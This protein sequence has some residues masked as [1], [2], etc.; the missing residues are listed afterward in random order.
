[1]RMRIKNI[2]NISLS[3]NT[4]V[5]GVL[6]IF[7]YTGRTAYSNPT[8]TALSNDLEVIYLANEEHRSVSYKQAIAIAFSPSAVP[9]YAYLGSAH[10]SL[11]KIAYLEYKEKH[12]PQIQVLFHRYHISQKK[13]FPYAFMYS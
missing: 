13:E 1:M 11:H 12:I 8:N 9:V 2:I 3:S 5:L 4:I 7:L 6:A 10:E